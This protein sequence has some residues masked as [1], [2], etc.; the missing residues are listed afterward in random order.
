MTAGKGIVHCEMFPL[1]DR[2]GKNPLELFQMWLNLPAEDKMVDPYFTMLWSHDTPTVVDAGPNGE[3][4]DVTLIAGRL[5]SGDTEVVA[6][7]PPPNSWAAREEADVAIWHL[8]FDPG[9]RW[10]MPAA[11]GA[12]TQRVIYPFT[13]SWVDLD[14]QR[15][16]AGTGALLDA[17]RDVELVAGDEG[18][19]CMV[20]QGRPIGEP[21]ARYGPFV[22][23]TDEEIRQA[24]EDY[25][26]TQFGG[27]PWPSDDPNHGA[28]EGRFAHHADG[29]IER[30]ER[31]AHAPAT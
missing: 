27:W 17:T 11:R 22:M 18:I 14:G 3:L 8:R 31:E 26:R 29:R 15:L 1:L 7:A 10:T 23:N 5:A 25:R 16:D 6:S 19:E 12:D 24:F 21:V 20:L 2:D 30:F 13:G 9:A 28:E 4:V